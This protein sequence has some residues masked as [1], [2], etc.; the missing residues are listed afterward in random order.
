MPDISNRLNPH[1][2]FYHEFDIYHRPVEWVSSS[3]H[4]LMLIASG[5]GIV[6]WKD[7]QEHP[8]QADDTTNYLFYLPP[9]SIRFVDVLND[10]P[11]HIIAVR[12][13][14]DYDDGSRFSE[15]YDVPDRLL[16]K[17]KA[18]IRQLMLNMMSDPDN[19]K[20][21]D[22]LEVERYFHILLGLFMDA[23]QLKSEPE[24]QRHPR[25]CRKAVIYLNKNYRESLNIDKLARICSVSRPYF[26]VLFKLENGMTAQQYLC[27]IRLEQARKLLMVSQLNIAEIGRE[28]GWNDPFHFSR[29][30]TRET[31]QSPSKFRKLK[32][33]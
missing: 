13:S 12:F 33:T 26:H 6:N 31:G 20:F 15:Y 23:A 17:H 9:D 22:R 1:L 29:I 2:E 21:C 25:R 30:F 14:L 5:V 28:V 3:M 4:V 27:R 18:E 8:V 7:D 24:L 32:L 11:M 19:Q 10:L 16:P